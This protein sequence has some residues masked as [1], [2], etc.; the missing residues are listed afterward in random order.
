MY[1]HIQKEVFMTNKDK[2]VLKMKPLP[3]RFDAGVMSKCKEISEHSE[4]GF[5]PSEIARD[6]MRIGL[7]AIGE[8][9]IPK[10]EKGDSHLQEDLLK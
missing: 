7:E 9:V 1:I 4:S 8:W 5:T 6:A 3:V 2:K 10:K